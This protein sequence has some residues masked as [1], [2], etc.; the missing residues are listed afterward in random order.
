MSSR[1][2]FLD[3]TFSENGPVKKTFVERD[4][5]TIVR[6]SLRKGVR[7]P[8]HR[9]SHSAFFLILKGKG[10]FTCED[11]EIE[12]GPNQYIH[13]KENEARG[14]QALEDLIILTI[15]EQQ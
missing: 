6:L 4:N 8:A 5:Y 9:G 2:I 11:G 3:L 10:I 15:M 13:I 12:L 7:V 1:D 14:I